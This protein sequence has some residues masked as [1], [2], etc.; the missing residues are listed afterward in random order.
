MPISIINKHVIIQLVNLLSRFSIV[1]VR[2]TYHVQLQGIVLVC[3]TYIPTNY[4][5]DAVCIPLNPIM[6]IKITTDTSSPKYFIK[7]FFLNV[8]NLQYSYQMKH[9]AKLVLRG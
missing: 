6:N 8:L 2:V 4:Y 5:G 3:H 1:Q 7:G 9:R